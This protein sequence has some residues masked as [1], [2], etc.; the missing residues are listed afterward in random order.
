MERPDFKP[1][2]ISQE[3]RQLFREIYKRRQFA[4]QQTVERSRGV[5]IL[6]PTLASQEPR[7]SLITGSRK[8]PEAMAIANAVNCG[9]ITVK[10]LNIPETPL[11]M[12]VYEPTWSENEEN[13]LIQIAKH[14][15]DYFAELG[16][17]IGRKTISIYRTL[18]DYREGIVTARVRFKKGLLTIGLKN[19]KSEFADHI[20]SFWGP[21]LN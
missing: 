19:P 5:H 13:K 2:P 7:I 21:T 1:A 10:E 8:R 3:N 15:P 9:S 16:V 12:L 4:L 11:E 6:I 17:N 20:N 18:K 14:L